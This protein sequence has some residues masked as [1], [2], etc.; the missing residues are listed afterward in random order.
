MDSSF[1]GT[2]DTHSIEGSFFW[3]CDVGPGVD[4]FDPTSLHQ[5]ELIYYQYN[6]IQFLGDS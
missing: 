4:Q 6:F 2:K 1:T 5:E 3:G